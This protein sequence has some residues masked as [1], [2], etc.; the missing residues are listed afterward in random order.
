MFYSPNLIIGILSIV[1]IYLEKTE[2][3]TAGKVSST[4]TNKT[5]LPFF[6]A[7]FI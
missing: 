2:S 3:K 1:L 5:G 6:T 4:S 7:D